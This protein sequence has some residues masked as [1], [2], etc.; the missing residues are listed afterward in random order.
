MG[1]PLQVPGS[2]VTS[3]PMTPVPASAGGATSVGAA[4][5]GSAATVRRKLPTAAPPELL[6]VTVTVTPVR[7]ASVEML[8]SPVAGSM[9][10]PS[11]LTPKV[12]AAPEK[13]GRICEES[14]F[15]KP[16]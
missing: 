5:I 12:R 1:A 11:P 16:E 10:T 15:L 6:A 13:L 7:S 4:V 9:A 2:S 8:S 3:L 14:G